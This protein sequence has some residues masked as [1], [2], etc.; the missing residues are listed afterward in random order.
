MRAR[1]T[2]GEAGPLRDPEAISPGKP[3]NNLLKTLERAAGIEPATF[4]LGS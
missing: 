3:A 2:L 1:P 4:S